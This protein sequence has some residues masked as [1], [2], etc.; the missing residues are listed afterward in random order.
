MPRPEIRHCRLCGVT[1]TRAVPEMEDRERPVCPDCGYVDYLNPINVVGTVPL[2]AEGTPEQRVLLCR[3]NIEPRKGY[4][5]LPAGFL[6]MDETMEAGAA[7][8]TAEEAGARVQLQGLYSVLDVLRAGQVH[9][10]YRARLLDLDLSPGPE[11][12]ENRLFSLD[13]IPWGELAFPTVR[14]TLEH[15]VSDQAL[16]A[17]SVHTGEITWRRS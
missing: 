4:W 13:E 5:T 7:R 1:M 14:R 8:E 10:F 12:I 2:W 15:L 9:V 6:E 3:R 17:Y 11:T 16:G